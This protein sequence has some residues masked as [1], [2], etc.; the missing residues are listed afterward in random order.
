MGG[1]KNKNC[2]HVA[3]LVFHLGTLRGAGKVTILY[4]EQVIEPF[5]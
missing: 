2:C 4:T 3:R 1:K 5:K